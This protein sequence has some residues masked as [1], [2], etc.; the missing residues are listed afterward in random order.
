MS[1]AQMDRE[2][3]NRY[4]YARAFLAELGYQVVAAGHLDSLKARINELEATNRWIPVG[5]RLPEPGQRV[6]MWIQSYAYVPGAEKLGA[7][8]PMVDSLAPW[9][10][11]WDLNIYE[12]SEVTHWLPLPKPPT[13]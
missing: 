3:Y 9:H 10:S 5:E 11:S 8:M 12:T 6:L 13:T 1:E 4:K 7:Y 2:K